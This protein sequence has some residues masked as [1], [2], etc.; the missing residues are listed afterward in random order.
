[1]KYIIAI[2]MFISFCSGLFCYGI[3]I[4]KKM[5]IA[6]YQD[7]MN[8]YQADTTAA[9][10]KANKELNEARSNIVIK[11]RDRVIVK[12]IQDAQNESCVSRATITNVLNIGVNYE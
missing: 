3:T 4:G 12:H 11:Y 2:I 1:M 9:V 5:Q 6:E 10:N 7:T 8:K